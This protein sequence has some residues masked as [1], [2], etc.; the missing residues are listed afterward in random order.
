MQQKTMSICVSLFLFI[1]VLGN[2]FLC[3]AE[4]SEEKMSLEEVKKETKDLL[5]A[6]KSYTIEQRDEALQKSRDALGDLDRKIDELETRI[7]EDWDKM[8]KAARDNA[9]ASLKALREKRT[10]AAEWY[11]SL[12]S[13]SKEAWANMKKG[14]SD[15]YRELQDAWEEYEEEYGSDEEAPPREGGTAL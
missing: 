6:L 13:S 15:A 9:R 14:F 2:P 1:A 12:K 8:D 3:S 5:Q 11:G 4:T 7:A 10:E